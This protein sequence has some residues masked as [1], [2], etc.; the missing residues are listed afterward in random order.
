MHRCCVCSE[1]AVAGAYCAAHLEVEA[2]TLT[3]DELEAAEDILDAQDGV[4]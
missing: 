2:S 1:P 3:L 4:E